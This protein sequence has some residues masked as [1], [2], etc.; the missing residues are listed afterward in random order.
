MKTVLLILLAL[1]ALAGCIVAP[2]G[3]DYSYGYGYG[4]YDAYPYA[5][6]GYPHHGYYRQRYYR[7]QAP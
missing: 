7:W 3:P 1:T 2:A 4:H 6:P 5:S